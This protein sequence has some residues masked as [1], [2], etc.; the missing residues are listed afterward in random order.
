MFGFEGVLVRVDAGL[1]VPVA[2]VGT[3][4][5]CGSRRTERFARNLAR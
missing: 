4:A 5:W 3:T 1:I 2:D